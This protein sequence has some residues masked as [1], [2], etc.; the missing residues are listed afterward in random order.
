M[1]MMALSY[2][3]YFSQTK[4]HFTIMGKLLATSLTSEKQKSH[5][6]FQWASCPN[7]GHV[8]GLLHCR[9]VDYFIE[10]TIKGNISKS[11]NCLL[12]PRL[13]IL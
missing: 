1:K 9:V 10:N 2:D 8:S 13:K 7:S 12:S 6:G 3:M 11:S 5:T 4:P